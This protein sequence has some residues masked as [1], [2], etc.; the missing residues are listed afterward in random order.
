MD[1]FELLVAEEELIAD[2][3]MYI[4]LL[5]KEKR[6]SKA[7][8]ARLL[9]VSK[10]S[11]S[12]MLS[13]DSNLTLRSIAR[14]A[15]LLGEKATICERKSRVHVE[16]TIGAPEQRGDRGKR[17]FAKEAAEFAE[18]SLLSS[19]LANANDNYGTVWGFDELDIAPS[20]RSKPRLTAA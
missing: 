18:L 1:E 12:Q 8:L 7:D 17:W 11:V 14:I 16:D 19:N 15:A 9:G 2:C 20:P 4:Y 3:Q 6:V 10:A 13:A 5:M